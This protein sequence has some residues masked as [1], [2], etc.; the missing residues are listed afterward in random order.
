MKRKCEELKE[1]KEGKGSKKLKLS[2]CSFCKKEIQ[3]IHFI[4]HL[5]KHPS[6]QKCEEKFLTEHELYI[7]MILCMGEPIQCSYCKK[8]F[9]S[10]ENY[11]EHYETCNVCKATVCGIGR[12]LKNKHAQCICKRWF[13][14]IEALTQH[15][16][17]RSC[18]LCKEENIASCMMKTHMKSK[19][20]DVEQKTVMLSCLLKGCKYL[21]R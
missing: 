3:D 8:K 2:S 16:S 21:C 13:M 11:D 20:P 7:H 10:S 4:Q 17:Y 6:C 5:A 18:Q 12:H 9:H 1:L 19:H 15:L 14:N